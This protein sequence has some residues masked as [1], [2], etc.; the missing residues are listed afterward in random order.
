[1]AYAK[2]GIGML[3]N[4]RSAVKRSSES[5]Q[6]IDE[7]RSIGKSGREARQVCR[8]RY[9][10][11]LGNAG[12]KL[13]ILP[14]QAKGVK[15]SQ[16]AQDQFKK[17]IPN[18]LGMTSEQIVFPGGSTTTRKSGFNPIFL[19]FAIPFIPGVRKFLGF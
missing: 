18:K 7:Q 4:I 11:R 10:S 3:Q 13:G 17:S 12:R 14:Q 8:D 19:L 15:V 6:C 9:G 1:M 5:R 2:T 16:F